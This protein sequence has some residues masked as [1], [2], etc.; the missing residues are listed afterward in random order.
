MLMTTRKA[1]DFARIL[2]EKCELKH[3]RDAYLEALHLSKE[4]DDVASQT[5]AISGLLRLAAEADDAH[6]IERWN[7]EL[8]VVM[9]RAPET[10]L[11][12]AWY[13]K[14]VV[15]SYRNEYR[16]AQRYYFK[17]LRAC[18]KV[19]KTDT[20][21]DRK[22]EYARIWSNLTATFFERGLKKR[23]KHSAAFLLARYEDQNLRGING[24]L[25]ILLGMF[26][27]S[28]G[29]FDT[30]YSW[31]QKAHRAFLQDRNW[32]AHLYVLYAY[33]RVERS[34]RDFA[35]AYWHLDLM[36]KASNGPE[37]GNLHQIIAEERKRLESDAIDLLID[38]RKCVV[39]TREAN[40]VN[41]GKQYVLLGIL[42]ALTEAHNRISAD[43]DRGLSKAEI[44][45]RVWREKY[46]PEAHDNKLYYNINRLRKLIEP[47]MKHPKYLLN[48]KDGYRLSP[49]IKVHYI[50]GQQQRG[51]GVMP[52]HGGVQ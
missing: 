38:S 40:E 15:S 35:Q 39:S 31:Y 19:L 50:G 52:G 44:I 42:E 29:Q 5:E 18:E 36:E 17:S 34:K 48:W 8:D 25:Y 9:Q 3:S 23:A 4:S 12:M 24:P 16:I 20:S 47:D 33:A 22:I 32:F 6:E 2:F 26:C 30:A 49:E 45:E 7:R 21:E 14:A 28:D 43:A 37:F 1:I 13:C 11:P 46:R 51:H 27:E 41:L 10:A